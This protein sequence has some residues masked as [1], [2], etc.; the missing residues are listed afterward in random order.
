[1]QHTLSYSPFGSAETEVTP[2]AF[3][4]VIAYE[5]LETGKRAKRI[6]DF[7]VENLG[8]DC[9]FGNQMWKFDV[10]SIPKLHQMAV[11]D[12]LS[13]DIIILSPRGEEVPA[14][15]KERIEE[16]PAAGGGAL[17][18]VALLDGSGSRSGAVRDYLAQIA[19]SA[20]MEF[21]SQPSEWSNLRQERT[22]WDHGHGP[23]A[24][25]L[26]ALA[27]AVQREITPRWGINE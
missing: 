8:M 24:H 19:K 15:L 20:R 26:T 3:N 2:S 16:G 27:G 23:V 22:E 5:D 6:Y 18:L 14:Q 4:V 17:A 12:L 11:R 7:L 10:L 1:M 21:F 13:A 9:P 25:T